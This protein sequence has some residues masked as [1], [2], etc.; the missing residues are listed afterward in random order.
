MAGT[1][2]VLAHSPSRHEARRT[3]PIATGERAGWRASAEQ[4]RGTKPLRMRTACWLGAQ[5]REDVEADAD[6]QVRVCRRDSR[7]VGVGEGATVDLGGLVA[8]ALRP[9]SI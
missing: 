2:R 8:L 1:Q 3:R 7:T 9:G 6:L 5:L 4:M